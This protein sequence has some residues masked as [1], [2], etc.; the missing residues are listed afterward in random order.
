MEHGCI[1]NGHF[2]FSFRP[3][4]LEAFSWHLRLAEMREYNSLLRMKE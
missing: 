4:P 1:R 3:D 2:D